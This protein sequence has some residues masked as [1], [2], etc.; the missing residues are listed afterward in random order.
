MSILRY[1]KFHSLSTQYKVVYALCVIIS[2]LLISNLILIRNTDYSFDQ[3]E[4]LANLILGDALILLAFTVFITRNFFKQ[5]IIRKRER[6]GYKLQSRI[7]GIVS[8][9]AAIPSIIIVLF[10]IYFFNLGIQNW[11]DKKINQALSDAAGI[12]HAYLAENVN[13][14]KTIALLVNGHLRETP[15][16]F[17]RIN[18]LEDVL[19]FLTNL[20]SLDEIV[21]VESTSGRIIA[22]SSFSFS[23][24][25]APISNEAIESAKNDQIVDIS[26]NNKIRVL[27][28]LSYY[29]DLYLV[30]GRLIDQNI[31]DYINQNSG[32]VDSY[33]KLKGN[34]VLL[35]VKFAIIFCILAFVL[36]I[37]ATTAGLIFVSR[38]IKPIRKLIHATTKIKKG[39]LDLQITTDAT[40]DEVG[41]LA[42]SFNE[43]IKTLN[44][45]RK[46][47]IIAQKTAAW[48]DMARMVAHE[49]NN[50]LTPIM[51]S[52]ERLKKKENLGTLTPEE[53]KKYTDIILNHGE[54]IKKIVNDFVNFAKLSNM[55]IS[56]VDIIA[57]LYKAV[58][59]RKILNDN[60]TYIFN[61]NISSSVMNCDKFQ[62]QQVLLN[63]LKNSEEALERTSNPNVMVSIH[64]SISDI[65]ITIEDNGPGVDQKILKN[66]GQPYITTKEKGSGIGI[67]IIKKILQQHDASFALKNLENKNGAVAELIFTKNRT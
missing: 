2:M 64:D 31:V 16:A 23:L 63:I 62:I 9:S 35:Q 60:I 41:I 19:N 65:I 56:S 47:L 50:P 53:F 33:N 8:A 44:K 27:M 39:N 10:S 42:N 57:L 67:A 1:L 15:I 32:T 26:T 28:K 54:D 21:I 22:Q 7:I 49:I 66:L 6:Q 38:I 52:V 5:W 30:V 55:Q 61:T 43:M 46:D 29:H 20:H 36:I 4:N 25:F 17:S 14:L 58:E 18:L 3:P 34:I 40:D 11:F 24:V 45:Q 37:L 12:A 13:S 51:L 59:E 48:S